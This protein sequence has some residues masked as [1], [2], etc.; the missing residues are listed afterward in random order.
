MARSFTST[1]YRAA[2]LSNT[3]GAVASG[4]PRRIVRRGKNIA[5]GRVLGKAGVWRRLWGG[6]R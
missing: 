3:I 2:R 6:G 4:H 1:L 5:V